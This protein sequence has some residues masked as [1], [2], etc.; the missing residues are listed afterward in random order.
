MKALALLAA[1]AQ[2][3]S[4]C[5]HDAMIVLDASASMDRSVHGGTQTRMEDGRAALFRILPRLTEARR[6]GLVTYGPGGGHSCDSVILRVA[7][8]AD[9]APLLAAV[10]DTAPG[11]STPLV[12]AVARAAAALGDD[13]ATVVLVTDGNDTCGGRPCEAGARMAEARP[14]LTVHVIGFHYA[15]HLSF[16]DRSSGGTNYDSVARCLAERTGGLYVTARTAEGLI[17][18]LTRTLGCVMGGRPAR[19]AGRG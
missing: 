7:P 16:I 1:L 10:A 9:A 6:I 3:A 17:D 4:A 2:P 19:G 13:P 15:R 5:L 8:T 18:A 12:A 14:D 11:G